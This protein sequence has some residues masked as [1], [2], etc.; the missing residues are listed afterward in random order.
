MEPFPYTFPMVLT[1]NT[2]NP[3][4]QRLCFIT[5]SREDIQTVAIA[6]GY[7]WSLGCG[8]VSWTLKAKPCRHLV[9]LWKE[10]DW[11]WLHRQ[12]AHAELNVTASWKQLS[13]SHEWHRKEPSASG[14]LP[15]KD[16]VFE[17]QNNSRNPWAQ[18]AEMCQAALILAESSHAGQ[19]L[20]VPY[21]QTCFIIHSPLSVRGIL[22]FSPNNTRFSQIMTSKSDSIFEQ[23][24]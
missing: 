3:C 10:E 13:G 7:V 14:Y 4:I 17:K 24:L 22:L 6:G 9:D 11:Q 19:D 5:A 15:A 12:E 8:S 21:C 23:K 1:P 16:F 18:Q 20:S 2:I